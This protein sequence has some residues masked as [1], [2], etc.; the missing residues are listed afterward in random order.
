MTRNTNNGKD[1][2]HTERCVPLSEDPDMI[3]LKKLVKRLDP[4]RRDELI[5]DLV[6]AAEQEEGEDEAA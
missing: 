6:D 4:D 1:S 2:G 5:E 3:R